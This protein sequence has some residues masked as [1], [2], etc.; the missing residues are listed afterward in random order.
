MPPELTLRYDKKFTNKMN[1][2]ILRQLISRLITSM[3]PQFSP[4]YKHH[5]KKL[6]RVKGTISLFKRND[7]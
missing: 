1:A 4:S 3:K 2:D 7:D 5:R 6:H